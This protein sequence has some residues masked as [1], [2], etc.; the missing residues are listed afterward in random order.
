MIKIGLYGVT[1][2]TGF[3]TLKILRRHPEIS[4]E[5]ATSENFAGQRISDVYPISWNTP[6]VSAAQAPLNTV[7][8]VFCCLPHYDKFYIPIA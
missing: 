3:E 5:F 7:E 8:A 1:G 4:L 2:Y 6:L